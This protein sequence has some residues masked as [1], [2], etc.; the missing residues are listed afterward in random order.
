MEINMCATENMAQ[1]LYNIQIIATAVAKINI[2][3]IWKKN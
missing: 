2:Y 3:S 1:K